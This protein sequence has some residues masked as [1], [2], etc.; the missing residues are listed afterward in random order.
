L[1]CESGAGGFDLASDDGVK[2]GF[3]LASDDGEDGVC[4]LLAF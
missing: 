3:D 1:R 4:N 2:G